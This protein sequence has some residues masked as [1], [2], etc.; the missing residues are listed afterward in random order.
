[1]IKKRLEGYNNIV[2]CINFQRS[3]HGR[4]SLFVVSLHKNMKDR[5]VF[6]PNSLQLNYEM[7]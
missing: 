5:I 6:V 3:Y 1:M 4:V 2:I 7:R